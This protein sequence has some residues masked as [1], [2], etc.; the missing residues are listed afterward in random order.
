MLLYALADLDHS[1]RLAESWLLLGPRQVAVAKPRPEGGW[2]IRS[3]DRSRIR[4]VHDAPGL[5][6]STLMLVGEPGSR[7]AP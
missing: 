1:L 2:D 6:A 7:G 4:A 5:S 3:F